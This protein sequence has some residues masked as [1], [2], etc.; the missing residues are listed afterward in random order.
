MTLGSVV[1][2]PTVVMTGQVLCNAAKPHVTQ[3]KKRNELH[4][5]P[6]DEELLE[7]AD[8]LTSLCSHL[9]MIVLLI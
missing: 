1:I 7:K 5:C 9:E 4:R 3:F 6:D 2:S 8:A